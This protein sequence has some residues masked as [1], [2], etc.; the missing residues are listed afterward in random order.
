MLI[1]NIG[2]SDDTAL[3][4][5]TNRPPPHGGTSSGGDWYEPDGTRVTAVPGFSRNR[6]SMVVR[7]RKFTSTGAP[8]EGMYKCEIK[9]TEFIYKT[10]YVGL[11]NSGGGKVVL[12]DGLAQWHPSVSH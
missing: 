9:D 11:Y 10:V 6:G 12:D 4:C 7:L 8:S 2:S 5:Y 3:L 1:S